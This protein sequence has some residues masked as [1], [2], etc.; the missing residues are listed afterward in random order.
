[1]ARYYTECLGIATLL[2]LAASIGPYELLKGTGK[3]A[4]EKFRGQLIRQGRKGIENLKESQAQ[5][6][7]AEE[8][9]SY[10]FECQFMVANRFPHC[11]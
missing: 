11:L 2:L 5:Q 8:F 9:G 1:M 7:T 3:Y 4:K 6:I 10:S